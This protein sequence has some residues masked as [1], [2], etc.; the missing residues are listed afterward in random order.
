VSYGLAAGLI[1]LTAAGCLFS[2]EVADFPYLAAFVV[3]VALSTLLGRG[4]A[5][6]AV[7]LAALLS[8]YL[9]IPPIFSFSFDRVTLQ[10]A[11]YYALAVVLILA[12]ARI[13]IRK[14]LDQKLKLI[15][16][17]LWQ[18]SAPA[19]EGGEAADSS[20]DGYIDGE[21]FG[22]ALD[23]GKPSLAPTI[24]V[25]VEDRL[26]GE[27][28]AVYYRP[29]VGS[30]SFYFDLTQYCAPVSGAHVDAR[31]RNGERLSNSPMLVNIP[32]APNG[33]DSEAVLFMHISKTAGTAFR[34]AMVK[35]Y[36]Q[37]E[38]AYIYPDPPGFLSDNLALLPLQ[39]RSRFRL[40]VGHFQYGIQQFLPQKSVYVS[41]VRDPV[42]RVIS[43]FRYLPSAQPTENAGNDSPQH[44]VELLEQRKMITIDNHMVRCFSGV[45]EKDVPAG[46]IDREVYKLALHHLRSAFAFVGYQEKSQAAYSS[47]QQKFG[48][49]PDSLERVN[50]A[51]AP[52]KEEYESVRA[53]IERFNHWD[54]L[55][56][57]EIQQLF[58]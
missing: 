15:L 36:K 16:F 21:I 37:S 55:L 14:G 26:I 11:G 28:N 7:I 47:L 30:H 19:R 44:L 57:S 8:D 17:Q 42:A 27:V 43:E 35:N 56:Y 51:R 50:A 48:W 13:P 52:F 23:T 9:F 41:I 38:V 24:T 4:P 20:V 39:Q 54:C 3:A 10:A 49:Q 6:V 46:S 53:A 40:V 18:S 29:D 5:I 58:P 22:W 31:L 1:L 2:R 45:S 32:L 33:G 34:E 25:Y 12:A